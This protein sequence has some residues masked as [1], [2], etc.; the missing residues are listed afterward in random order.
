MVEVG[1]IEPPSKQASIISCSLVEFQDTPNS[2]ESSDQEGCSTHPKW[3][4][5]IMDLAKGFEDD[6][7]SPVYFRA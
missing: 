1:G 7:P 5:D 4:E 6:H 3:G 2:V